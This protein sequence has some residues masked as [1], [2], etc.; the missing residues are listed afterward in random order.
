MQ[1]GGVLCLAFS[2]AKG[3]LGVGG[4][5]GRVSIWSF[6]KEEEKTLLSSIDCLRDIQGG[7]LSTD[8]TAKNAWANKEKRVTK[9]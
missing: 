1:T 6:D 4:D 3:L 7:R 8:K 9:P 2:K 5:A